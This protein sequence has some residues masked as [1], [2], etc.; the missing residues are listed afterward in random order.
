MD[1]KEKI[2][3]LYMSGV[4]VSDISEM[5]SIT[6]EAVY[7]KLRKSSGWK[8]MKRHHSDYRSSTRLSGLQEHT[9]EIVAGWLA[10]VTMSDLAKEFGTIR[11]T[12]SAIIKENM[13]T[14]KRRYKRDLEIV[15][16]Y[17]NGV[18]QVELSKR[19]GISQ[20]CISRIVNAL[21]D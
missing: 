4:P 2:T 3:K 11:K 21:N 15:E 18:T 20:P 17:N 1:N 13:G 19:Y 10:G 9:E 7:Q 12:I 8:G 16:A 14:T 6:R 5:F